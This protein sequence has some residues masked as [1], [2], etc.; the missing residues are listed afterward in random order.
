MAD[1]P[2]LAALTEED[3]LRAAARFVTEG[4]AD[5]VKI[6][7]DDSRTGWV[8]TLA[9]AGIATV[10]HLGCRPQ[11]V[12]RAGGYR[13]AGKTAEDRQQLAETAKNMEDAGAVMLL[14]EAAT[15][16]AA[17]AILENTSLPLI[18]CGAGPDCDGQIVVTADLLGLTP[19]QPSFAP[20]MVDGVA[21]L[22]TM[23]QTW[24]QTVADRQAG[25]NYQ[26]SDG[27]R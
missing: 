25:G 22:A 18:G 17:R 4:G 7:M 12:K 11:H 21:P 15:P 8:K 3:A 2:F 13:V 10:P 16:E 19:K 26:T 14:L 27:A 6:E 9:N 20:P 24:I 5:A 23:A 1:L